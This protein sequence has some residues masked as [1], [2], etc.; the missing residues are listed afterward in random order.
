MEENTPSTE[1]VEQTATA[2]EETTPAAAPVA[3]DDGSFTAG[4]ID[5][6]YTQELRKRFGKKDEASAT[7]KTP[8]SVDKAETSA[9]PKDGAPESKPAEKAPVTRDGKHKKWWKEKSPEEKASISVKQT[10]EELR[11]ANEQ[12]AA[13]Q[14][15]LDELKPKPGKNGE[16]T[17]ADFDSERDWQRYLVDERLLELSA[18]KAAAEKEE[19]EIDARDKARNAKWAQAMETAFTDPEERQAAAELFHNEVN[20]MGL[21]Q[22]VYDYILESGQPRV[23]LHIVRHPGAQELL[24]AG[25]PELLVGRRLMQIEKYLEGQQTYKLVG[26][27]AKPAAKTAPREPA[28]KSATG[29]ANNIGSASVATKSREADQRT[30]QARIL[31][32][33]V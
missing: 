28:L 1:P 3:T 10:R 33:R 21:A 7:E 11:K 32:L 2:T 17:R 14:K 29:S 23:L 15:Q 9:G 12:I 24:K 25:T 13:L 19:A 16:R 6:A 20:K 27:T 30:L 5:D 18:E 22:S 26:Q 31:G 8:E 4:S